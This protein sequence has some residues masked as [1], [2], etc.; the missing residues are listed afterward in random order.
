VVDNDATPRATVLEVRTDDGP[1]V[2][3]RV[4]CLLSDAG[5]DIASAKVETL[6]HEV[7]DTFYVR[8]AEDGR[9]LTD[10]SAIERLRAIL[11]AGVDAE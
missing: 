9:K 5:L 7:V 2:L 11:L 1:G 3:Y 6:G 4:A 10:P 8:T